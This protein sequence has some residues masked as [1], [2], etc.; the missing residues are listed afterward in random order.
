[1]PAPLTGKDGTFKKDGSA[2]TVDVTFWRFEPKASE[3]RFASDKTSGT[4][5]SY[6]SVKDWDAI[7]RVKIPASGT[8]PFNLDDTFAMQLHG[9]DTG[10]NYISANGIILGSPIPCDINEGQDS[11]VEFSIGPRGPALYHGLYWAGAG[12]SGQ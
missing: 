2:L 8:L 11:E 10:N 7:V 1:M 6:V 12:S 3:Q 9:D 5:V 4:K